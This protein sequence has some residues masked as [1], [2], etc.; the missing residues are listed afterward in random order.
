M[1]MQAHAIKPAT[2]AMFRSQLK[3]TPLPDDTFSRPS[4]PNTEVKTTAAYG[5]PLLD[6]PL[7]SFGAKP[8]F[9]RPTRTREPENTHEFAAL[10]TTVNK[11]PLM[12][13]GRTGTPARLAAMTRG[14]LAASVLPFSSCG[15]S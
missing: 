4:N 13:S 8:S 12:M 6:V 14:E 3:T 10:K 7:K 9:A 2:P 15:L 1:P 5:T 11:T